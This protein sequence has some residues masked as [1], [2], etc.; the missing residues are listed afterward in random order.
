MIATE[1]PASNT[2][3]Y[4]LPLDYHPDLLPDKSEPALGDEHP[5]DCVADYMKTSQSHYYNYYGWGWFSDIGPSMENYV[6]SLGRTDYYVTVSKLYMH[7]G[8]NW[9]SFRVEIDAGRP[10]V[11]L[12]DTDGNDSTDHFVT[13]VGYDVVDDARKYACLYTWDPHI[14]WFDLAAIASGQ[15]WGIFGAITFG[16]FALPT[17]VTIAGPTTSVVGVW[18]HLHRHRQ[19]DDGNTPDHLY[20]AGCRPDSGDAHGGPE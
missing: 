11:L 6:S 20:L 5:D 18:L 7:G 8:L 13:A 15:P 3:D 2:T 14:H 1:G 9:D 10:V 12:V 4:C 19:P 17:K 16:I